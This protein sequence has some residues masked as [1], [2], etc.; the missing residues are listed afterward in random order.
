MV[1]ALVACGLL[2]RWQ[3]S[4]WHDHRVDNAASVTR[5]APV[6]LDHVLGP[7]AAFPSSGVGRP[8]VVAGR[9]D[10]AHTVYVADR[11][12][13]GH[14]GVWAV[15]PVVTATGSAIPVVRGWTPSPATAAAAPSGRA[16]LVG[17]LQ[18]SDDTGAVDANPRDDVVPA[19]SVTALLPRASYDLYDAFVVATGRSLP[20][21]G[22][23]ANGMSGLRPVTAE[24]LPGADASTALRNL[25]YAVQWWVFGAFAVFVWW[26]WLQ[27]DVLGRRRPPAPG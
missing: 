9:W 11:P 14:T 26:R 17:L 22:V 8:V 21:G 13:D 23:A 15:T 5:E 4:V 1:V 12:Y 7:D 2:G 6:P 19:L 20:A 24:H 10:P 27:E 16:D 25:L 18:P 3:L